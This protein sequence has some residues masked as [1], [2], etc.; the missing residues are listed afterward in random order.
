MFT[1]GTKSQQTAI[2]SY[3][4]YQHNYENTSSSFQ[5]KPYAPKQ[6]NKSIADFIIP[7]IVR[8][9]AA[10]ASPDSLIARHVYSPLSVT[11]ISTENQINTYTTIITYVH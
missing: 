9:A 1:D 5:M 8:N 11:I 7:I 4:C 2:T 6:T 10:E 3:K